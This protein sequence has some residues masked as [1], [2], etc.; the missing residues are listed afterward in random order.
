MAELLTVRICFIRRLR[1]R[2][3]QLLPMITQCILRI[4]TGLS[5]RNVQMRKIFLAVF[6]HLGIGAACCFH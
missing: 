2:I 3:E 1:F 6:V 5:L 4:P